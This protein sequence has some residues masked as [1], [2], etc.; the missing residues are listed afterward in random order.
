M[1][2]NQV[3]CTIV[4]QTNIRNELVDLEGDAIYTEVIGH[5]LGEEGNSSVRNLMEHSEDGG[6]ANRTKNEK[7]FD[8]GKK[9][10]LDP[11]K[12][13]VLHCDEG[14]MTGIEN[15]SHAK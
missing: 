7:N 5:H 10:L 12:R 8:E 15:L 14:P 13:E 1:R 6:S 9:L 2:Q 4:E 3:Q 11:D